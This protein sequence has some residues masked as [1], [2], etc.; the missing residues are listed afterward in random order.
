MNEKGKLCYALLLAGSL[1]TAA[2]GFATE[3]VDARI[4][5]L[6]QELTELK[7]AVNTKSSV[8]SGQPE[9]TKKAESPSAPL[10]STSSGTKIQFY[11]FTRFDAS[12]DAGK[13]NSGNTARWA[14]PEGQNNDAE[15]N[16]TA[17]ATRL[18]LNLGGPDTSTIKLTG[19]IEFDF[20]TTI[21]AENNQVPRLR[22]G[23][24]KAYWPASDFSI[25]AGQTWDVISSL[26]PFVDDP[27]AMWDAG[28]IG[29]RH[30]QLRLTKGF[31]TGK[32]GRIEVA[33]AA[34]RTI[35]EKN[36]LPDPVNRTY[37]T[38][39]GKDAVIPTIQGRIAYSV[40][41][42]VV[43]QPATLAL[44]G[45]YGQEEWDTDP[46]GTHNTL[47]SW[48]CNLELTMPICPKMTLAGEY[49]TGSNLDDYYGGISQGVNIS[50]IKE[51]RSKGGWAA[52]RVAF[53]SETSFSL[54]AGID[55][56]NNSDLPQFDSTWNKSSRTKN[57]TIFGTLINK[58]TPN[59]I[60]GLQLAQWKTDYFN[61]DR[62][63]A[64]RAQSSITYKF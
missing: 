28:N 20:L 3:T 7:T 56:P 55:D 11:G 57:Q 60:L 53:N 36:N 31:S 48:S 8:N 39:P 43:N 18:G 52:L 47:D 19:N 32:Q 24:L 4:N 62:G 64:L 13:I 33:V 51:I 5:R 6:E 61:G 10:I 30:P 25:I 40:P 16:L 1:C 34:A 63:N 58:I 44:S 27:A 35:G 23:Y 15:W 42:L 2:P 37:N 54:G 22:H 41:L 38:D 21:S 29:S 59:L 9:T 17:G 26:I 12:Y 45:H 49:F 46:S 14:W 50:T